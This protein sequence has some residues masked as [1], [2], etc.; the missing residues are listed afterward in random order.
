MSRKNAATA[1]GINIGRKAEPI[2]NIW[3]IMGRVMPNA[4]KRAHKSK[5]F[6]SIELRIGLCV[7]LRGIEPLASRVRF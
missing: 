3:K 7:E 6:V 5:L 2:P 1:S 4:E